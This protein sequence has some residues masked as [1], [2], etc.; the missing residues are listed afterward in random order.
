MLYEGHC[1]KVKRLSILLLLPLN[2]IGTILI[3]TSNYVMQAVSAPTRQEVDRSHAGGGFRNIGMPTS[4]DMLFSQPYN[5]SHT[6]VSQFV[7]LQY[8]ADEQLRY[9]DRLK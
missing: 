7:Y 5:G 8:L 3:S 1:E 6:F 4:Y 9:H 2:I